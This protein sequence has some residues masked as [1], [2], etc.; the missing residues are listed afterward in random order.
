MLQAASTWWCICAYKR[1]TT[2]LQGQASDD[3]TNTCI[4]DRACPCTLSP[5]WLFLHSIAHPQLFMH[6]MQ[7]AAS[8]M[9]QSTFSLA[10]RTKAC[11][12]RLL[13]SSAPALTLAACQWLDDAHY[14]P[15]RLSDVGKGDVPG[16][17]V[18]ARGMHCLF[19]SRRAVGTMLILAGWVSRVLLGNPRRLSN[20]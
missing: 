8:T 4:A 15:R 7:P 12:H 1:H 11:P 17:T 2:R 18:G 6:D 3:V 19:L 16:G 13:R 9:A 14:P 20:H 10:S 5:S